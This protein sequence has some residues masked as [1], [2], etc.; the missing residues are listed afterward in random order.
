ME[1]L[2]VLT[3]AGISVESGIKAFRS[4]DGLWENYRVEDVATHSAWYRNPQLILDFYNTMR[5]NLQSKQPN[6]AHISIAERELEYD[7]SVITQNVDNLHERAGSS[8]VLHLHGELTK[9]CSSRD[10]SDVS[11][12]VE[13]GYNP[14]KM[15]DKANDGSQLR[16]QI[17]FFEEAVPNIE[18]AARLV[19]NADILM[20]IGTS[21]QVY[22]AAGLIR[23]AKPNVPIYFIDPQP[24]VSPQPNLTVIAEPASTGVDKAFE[25]IEEARMNA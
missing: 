16:P 18:P 20:I 25:M 8:K 14:I 7:I 10:E 3:G 1:K 15:G 6:R 22:P 21:M 23:Y 2:V 24:R 9:A 17:V 5:T 13:I 4:E 19:Q 12:F 11:T